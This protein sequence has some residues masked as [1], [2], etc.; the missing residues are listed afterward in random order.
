MFAKDC[1][2]L[3]AYRQLVNGEEVF[4]KTVPTTGCKWRI[5][6]AL[7]VATMVVISYADQAK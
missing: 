5:P 3:L 4:A 1:K 7:N 2:G 6:L